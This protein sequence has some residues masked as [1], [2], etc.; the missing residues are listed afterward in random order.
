MAKT[1]IFYGSTTGTTQE[2]AKL[3][4]ADLNI[5]DSDVFN[6]ADTAPS[7]VGNYD[8]IILGSSTWGDGD[9]QEDMEDF[10][11]GLSSLTLKGKTIALFGCGDDS[12]E[13][14]FCNAVGIMYE[15]LQQTG[16]TFIGKFNATG[17]SIGDSKAIVNGEPVGLLLDQSNHPDLTDSRIKAWCSQ[18]ETE[19]K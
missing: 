16:A 17:Y 13:D 18:I 10:I 2:V 12:N 15:R 11:T 3:I 5:N 14:T 4:A 8:L 1:G 6:V 19:I 7:T 9:L